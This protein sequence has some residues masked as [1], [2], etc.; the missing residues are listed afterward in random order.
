MPEKD[1]LLGSRPL[2]A[3]ALG[4]MLLV[5]ARVILAWIWPVPLSVDEA[6]YVAWSRELQFGYYS[7]PPLMGC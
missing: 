3:W 1:S 7:K 2:P 5:I 6:Q 4:L